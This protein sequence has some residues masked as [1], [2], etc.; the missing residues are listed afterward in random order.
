MARGFV[1][2]S[3]INQWSGV[4]KFDNY[5]RG[6]LEKQKENNIIKTENNLYQS[7]HCQRDNFTRTTMAYMQLFRDEDLKRKA[8]VYTISFSHDDEIKNGLTPEKAHQMSMGFADKFFRDYPAL[9]VTHI[10]TKNLHTQIMVGNVNV[11][12]GKSW[13]ENNKLMESMKKEWGAI[14]LK[15]G[16]TESIK[17]ME[18]AERESERAKEESNKQNKKVYPEQK[19]YKS[20]AERRINE[21]GFATDKDM[22]AFRITDALNR[23]AKTLDEFKTALKKDNID[24][25]ERGKRFTFIYTNSRGKDG[26]KMRDNRLA[27]SQKNDELLRE[28]I[29]KRIAENA[30]MAKRE[31]I[32]KEESEKDKEY[33]K[34]HIIGQRNAECL[35]EAKTVQLYDDKLDDLK[36]NN[37]KIENQNKQI[38]N[39]SGA[40]QKELLEEKEQLL[41]AQDDIRKQLDEISKKYDEINNRISEIDKKLKAEYPNSKEVKEIENENRPT[42]NKRE[43]QRLCRETDAL[44]EMSPTGAR[45]R[46]TEAGAEAS[47]GQR[48]KQLDEL[49]QKA[50]EQHTETEKQRRKL[51]PRM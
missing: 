47:N 4:Q 23:G 7:F 37:E 29:E 33:E 28:N 1:K 22:L 44:K 17:A 9:M 49:N 24:V 3:N 6:E 8:Y 38:I 26:Q 11:N 39:E 12:T 36:H 43:M 32:N 35:K 13:Q 15:N 48:K 2:A 51:T 5:L 45:E 19:Y 27:E 31:F 50:N 16:M 42:L 40:R 30:E 25:Q 18:K 21:R 20:M 10:D 14:L 34:W 41:K 46:V